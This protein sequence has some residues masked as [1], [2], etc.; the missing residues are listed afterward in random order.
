ME[1]AG[2]RRIFLIRRICAIKA[3]GEFGNGVGIH[4]GDSMGASDE[5]GGNDGP[6]S[7]RAENAGGLDI[8]GAPR[9]GFGDGNGYVRT[10]FFGAEGRGNRYGRSK[11]RHGIEGQAESGQQ[12]NPPIF[13]FHRLLGMY[14]KPSMFG[15]AGQTRWWR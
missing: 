5:V 1:G 9:N 2:E 3:D 11:C 8:I 13:H 12:K 10:G 7:A 6:T 15:K 14:R 4:E